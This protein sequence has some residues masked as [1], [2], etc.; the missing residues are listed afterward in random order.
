MHPDANM[1][2]LDQYIAGELIADE[3]RAEI[4]ELQEKLDNGD[5]EDDE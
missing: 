1:P 4:A 2:V 3:R 5:Y